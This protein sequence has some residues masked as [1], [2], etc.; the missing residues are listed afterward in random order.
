MYNEASHVQF[1]M[2]AAAIYS[3]ILDELV[4]SSVRLGL[5]EYDKHFLFVSRL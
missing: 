4:A 3:L 2:S 5:V 1:C